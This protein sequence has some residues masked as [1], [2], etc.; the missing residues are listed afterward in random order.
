M[1]FFQSYPEELQTKAEHFEN[2]LAPYET[3]IKYDM[4]SQSA[5]KIMQKNGIKSKHYSQ[6]KLIA[7]F[8]DR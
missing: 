5:K 4:L 8:R 2:P 1:I 7:D 3:I 6:K